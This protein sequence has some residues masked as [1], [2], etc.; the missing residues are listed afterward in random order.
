MF[1]DI[2]A[3]AL[4]AVVVSGCVAE[5]AQFSAM[6]GQQAIVRD[7]IPAIQSRKQYSIALLRPAKRQF[8]AGARPAYVL[9]IFSP[10][11]RA[12]NFSVSN[13]HIHQMKGGV[14]DKELHL[15]TYEELV[16]E[17][18]TRQFV[19]A[20]LTVT[21]AAANSYSASKQG[22]Y[23]GNAT[24]YGPRGVSTVHVSGYS[25]V[26]NAIAQDRA[27]SQNEAMIAGAI[28]QG[29]ANLAA[30]EGTIIK[31][32]TVMPGEWYGGALVFDAP[33]DDGGKNFQISVQI[34]SDRHEFNVSHV[35]PDA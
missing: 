21:A 5:I 3:A 7:G 24:V 23:S 27:A 15:Y 6:P 26:A 8:Q 29:Q 22:Y 35:R 20:L 14:R 33:Q 10:T 4:C 28:E 1:K 34:G 30:L 31:D 11:N 2:F 9:A 12:V 32:N 16:Q 18:K 13:V 17:E 19:G 25:P